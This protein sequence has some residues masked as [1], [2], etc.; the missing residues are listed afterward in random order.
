MNG[1]AVG[2]GL[3]AVGLLGAGSVLGAQESTFEWRQS[4]R[5]GQVLS[6]EGIVGEIRA[7]V[8]PGG[9]A[10][11][12]AEKEGR[13]A[14]FGE[15]EIRVVEERDG[16]RI[17]AVYHPHAARGGGCD[18]DHDWDGGGDR[19]HSVDVDVH[20]LVRVPAGVTF[21][22]SMVSGDISAQGLDSDVRANTV[23]GDVHVSTTGT[24]WGNTV[25]GSIEIEMG[26]TDWRE[27][28]FRTVSGDITLWLPE[29]IDVDVDFE[30]LSGDLDSD[31][32]ITQTGRRSRR[33]IGANVEGYIGARGER[34]LS[35]NTVSGD[36]RLRRAR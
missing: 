7:E 5:P 6:V 36:V 31:F 28:E 2:F 27:L 12:M 23:D 25:S 21:Q 10:L 17:C 32:E 11:V 35:F 16:Y 24:A 1:S 3:V 30:S 18:N 26:A 8:A 4:M 19:R 9:T 15:V 22:G 34:S 14:D 33:W 13:T 29:D 20:Y